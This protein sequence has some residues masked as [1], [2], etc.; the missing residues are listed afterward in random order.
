MG[1]GW[2]QGCIG[3]GGGP[4]PQGAQPMPSHCLPDAKYK[5]QRHL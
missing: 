2:G 5:L 1:G 3:T 4:P